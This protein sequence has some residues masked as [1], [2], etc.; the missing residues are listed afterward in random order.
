MVCLA[1]LVLVVDALA[2]TSQPTTA[3]APAF[4]SHAQLV[5]QASKEPLI[6]EEYKVGGKPLA[7]EQ[8][9]EVENANKLIDSA[10]KARSEGKYAEAVEA[11]DKALAT[12]KQTLG[13]DYHRTITATLLSRTLAA[14][15]SASPEDQKKLA[16]SDKLEQTA[17]AA[18]ETGDYRGALKA[19]QEALHLREAVLGKDHP[20]N[21]TLLRM[22]GADQIEL[23]QLTDAEQAL[24]R[25]L[26]LA[27]DTYGAQHPNTA[28]V[29]DRVGWLRISQ[30]KAED[31][32]QSLSRAVRIF[33][34]TAGE[35]AELAEALDNL[36]T[37]LVG[38]RDADRALL[39]K[40][41]AYV[42]REQ[43]LGPEARDTAVSL[44]NLAWLY[45]Q[46]GKL[47]P[48]EV[49]EQRKR[50]L[51]IF[52]KALGPEHAWTLLERANLARQYVS[53]GDLE[54][55]LKLYEAMAQTDQAHPEK[56]DQRVIDRLINLGTL[57]LGAGRFEDGRR[58]LAKA[59][60]SNKTL[61]EKGDVDPAI[62]QQDVLTSAY[63]GWRLYE[64]A[65]QAGELAASWAQKRA[66]PMDETA[67]ARVQRLGSIYKE[68]GKLQDA[69]RIL[70]DA[71]RLTGEIAPKE[72]LRLVSTELLLSSV[73]I[74]L[75]EL[76][77]AERACD[78]ALRAT[79]SSMPKRS[80]GQAYPLIAM[81]RIQTIQKQYELAS[82]SLQEA[83]AILEKEENRRSDPGAYLNALC[84]LS[85][86]RLAQGDKAQAIE[87]ARQAVSLGRSLAS[88]G[89][90]V[91]ANALLV[92]ALK[93]LTEALKADLP[94]SQKEYD[95]ALADIKKLLL[96]LRDLQ[97]LSAEHAQWLKESE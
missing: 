85:A 76:D 1:C 16:E 70:K 6:K 93:K 53:Q 25:A 92:D 32:V 39:S 54:E 45:S 38:M 29:L 17:K 49:L 74:K 19:A 55:G 81:G 9:A 30:N 13:Q 84:E 95:A 7:D 94:A 56:L 91:N 34:S 58:T 35:T 21:S 24:N 15:K 28:L 86:C 65:A 51:A 68:L 43:V 4:L 23:G 87:L 18:H 36:G 57:Y 83:V 80:R 62:S 60:E 2:Q 41:R 48:K 5:K 97:A 61:Y 20:E 42:I 79:E 33:R 26:Q 63:Q 89:R 44:S 69:K 46:L 50:A 71:L 66:A 11:C 77:E 75:G 96:E 40:L 82:F 73:Y 90:N 31:A 37:A 52:E 8:L 14:F 88:V 64:A 27:T 10:V 12:Y 3:S 78:Q 22:M 72:P 67:V 59:A 47:D